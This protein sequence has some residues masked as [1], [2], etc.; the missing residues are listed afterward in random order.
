MELE[1]DELAEVKIGGDAEI[2]LPSYMVML[3]VEELIEAKRAAQRD[4]MI[5]AAGRHPEGDIVVLTADGRLM[6]LKKGHE[7][8]P[9]GAVLPM[10]FGH[11]VAI[12]T[13]RGYHEMAA[14]WVI[15]NA[16]L[17]VST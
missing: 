14:G 3:P 16:R 13:H 4:E 7:G 1:L 12:E 9:E 10:D 11:T 6:E 8:I 17:L 5:I 15:D 2:E